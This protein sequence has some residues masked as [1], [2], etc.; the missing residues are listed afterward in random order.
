M[1]DRPQGLIL[2]T[3]LLL[4]R[5]CVF[6]YC[7]LKSANGA[8]KIRRNYLPSSSREHPPLHEEVGAIRL[9][10]FRSGLRR[11]PA[12]WQGRLRDDE[13]RRV[14]ADSNP[15]AAEKAESEKIRPL[16]LITPLRTHDLKLCKQ[17]SPRYL[18]INDLF[19]SITCPRIC[20]LIIH[21]LLKRLRLQ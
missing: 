21:L 4:L 5:L 15:P 16:F 19:A 12:V 18:Q 2:V 11:R 17:L 3:I 7:L 20:Q 9:L 8:E 10:F 6:A 1:L 13:I 14:E